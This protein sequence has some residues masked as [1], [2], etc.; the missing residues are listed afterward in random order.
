M[1]A[2]F[3]QCASN[4]EHIDTLSMGMSDDMALAIKHGSTMLRIGTAIFGKRG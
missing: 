1:K 3:D 4:F 2:L